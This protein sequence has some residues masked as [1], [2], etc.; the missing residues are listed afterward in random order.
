MI[1]RWRYNIKTLFQNKEYRTLIQ[2]HFN[3]HNIF[4][5]KKQFLF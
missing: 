2:K 3:I 5:L 1:H 4:I